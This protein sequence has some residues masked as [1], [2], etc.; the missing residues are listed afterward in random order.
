[1]EKNEYR[2]EHY[3]I[4]QLELEQHN[5]KSLATALY[6]E[7]I[8]PELRQVEEK[9]KEKLANIESELN[10]NQN[11]MTN[12]PTQKFLERRIILSERAIL[13]LD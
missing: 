12:S 11:S 4:K 10:M 7:S 6:V 3:D 1:M 2:M 8:L 9:I 13:K 5:K